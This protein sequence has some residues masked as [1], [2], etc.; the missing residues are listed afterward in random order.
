MMLKTI[1]DINC[2]ILLKKNLGKTSPKCDIK[3]RGDGY[4]SLISL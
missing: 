3:R 1:V 2:L 4:L